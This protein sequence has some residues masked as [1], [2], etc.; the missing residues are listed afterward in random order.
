MPN[1]PKELGGFQIIN[2][3]LDHLKNKLMHYYFNLHYSTAS[4]LSIMY[5][6][7]NHINKYNSFPDALS[8]TIALKYLCTISPYSNSHTIFFKY[9]QYERPTLQHRQTR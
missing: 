1:E 7:S 2:L 9:N 4:G 5:L 6:K 8:H 3:L